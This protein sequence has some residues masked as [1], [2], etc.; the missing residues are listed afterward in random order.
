[1]KILFVTAYEVD[2]DSSVN[3]ANQALIK[4]FIDAG[5]DVST[6]SAFKHKGNINN[7][8]IHGRELTKR[9]NLNDDNNE[10]RDK[11]EKFSFFKSI[12]NK[13]LSF[14]YKRIYLKFR[15]YDLDFE[16]VKL[17][18]K[19]KI[20]E[21]F[22]LMISV[23]DPKLTHLIASRLVK[24]N[25]N[26]C[27]KW[28]QYW[29]NP[30]ASDINKENI[31]PRRLV[32]FEEKRVIKKCDKVIYVSPLTLADNQKKYSG[33]KEKMIFLP[34][35]Y[36]EEVMYPAKHNK[37][38]TIGYFGDYRSTTVNIM[39]L[40]NVCKE[41]DKLIICGDSNLTL[42][43][44]DHVSIFSRTDLKKMSKYEAKC[45]LLVCICT[46]KGNQISAKP[47]WCAR[48]NKKILIILDGN[49][50]EEIKKYFDS[51]N[52][53]YF[54]NNDEESIK[55]TINRIKTND[56]EFNPCGQFSADAVVEDILAE[57]L[58]QN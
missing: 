35:P 57:L 31:M 5:C 29:N 10:A 24:K 47:I 16:L 50:K 7:L 48:T 32:A 38:Y 11:K 52:R 53:F 9:Y 21:E 4:G 25:P 8:K 40:Y 15:I 30:F 6:I 54:C 14:L 56:R 28:F 44:N 19:F 3:I 55:I 41:N 51:Y 42:E 2:Y 18:N 17:A 27:K 46:K 12:R 13:L 58:K 36:L 22:D 39:P 49:R 34:T 1:M 20:N 33:L 23:S 37:E 26:L 43:E 45:D